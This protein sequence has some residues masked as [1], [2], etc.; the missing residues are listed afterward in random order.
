MSSIKIGKDS[1]IETLINQTNITVVKYGA[2]WCGPCKMLA[3]VLEKL[4]D[5]MGDVTFVDVDVDDDDAEMTVKSS[6]VSSV[7]LMVFYKN[8]QPV[9]RVLGFRPEEEIVRIIESL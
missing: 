1:N 8:G 9:N 3:L 2:T 7:P 4:A 6:E 5:E